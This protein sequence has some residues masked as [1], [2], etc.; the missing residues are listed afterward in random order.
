MYAFTG[1][2]ASNFLLGMGCRSHGAKGAIAPCLFSNGAKGVES[3]P[4]KVRF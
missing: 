4:L 3:A 2:V 1:V